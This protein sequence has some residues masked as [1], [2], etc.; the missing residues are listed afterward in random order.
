MQGVAYDEK[1]DKR[2]WEAM[3]VFF[4]EI[5]GQEKARQ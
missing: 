4:A 5:F 1:T 3:R 2:S